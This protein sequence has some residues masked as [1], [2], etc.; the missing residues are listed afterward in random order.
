MFSWYPQWK[1]GF[2]DGIFTNYLNDGFVEEYIYPDQKN[3]KEKLSIFG[4]T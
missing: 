4:G 2:T 3:I 1:N